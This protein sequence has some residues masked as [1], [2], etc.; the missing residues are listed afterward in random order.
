MGL[1]MG[2]SQCWFVAGTASGAIS[3]RLYVPLYILL[4]LSSIMSLVPL[5]MFCVCF[6]FK[7]R[8]SNRLR[9]KAGSSPFTKFGNELVLGA[10]SVFRN[11]R[12]TLVDSS[13]IYPY[14]Y[15]KHFL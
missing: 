2:C 5:L 14:I 8:T 15:R 10:G 13:P 7:E 11:R 4:R 1:V 3:D 9:L 6:L 12:V